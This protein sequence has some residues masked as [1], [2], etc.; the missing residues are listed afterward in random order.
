[1]KFI[2]F[3]EIASTN[4]YLKKKEKLEEY[5]VVAAKRQTDGKGKRGSVWISGEGAA[6]F[7]FAV[8]YD[9]KLANRITIFAGYVVYTVLKG[10]LAENIRNGLT[11]KWPND[12][13]FGDK[14]ICGILCEKV[15]EHIIVGIGININ[16]TDFGIF[17]E[18]AVSLYEISGKAE[19][20][21]EIIEKTVAMFSTEISGINERWKDILQ[22]INE[23]SYLKD[24]I[25][26][27]KNSGRNT[28]TLYFKDINSSGEIVLND[29]ET[30]KIYAYSS[31]DFEVIKK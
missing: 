2:K 26:R 16:N 7:S 6:L 31:L 28:E 13:Y 21:D 20:V 10:Y 1:M 12:I 22:L 30:N 3:D 25:L 5:E 18:K 24:K 9:E 19:N 14:K 11:F 15:R 27:I 8:G 23:R 17:S 4:D 29:P